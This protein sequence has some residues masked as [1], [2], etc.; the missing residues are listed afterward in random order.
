M[1]VGRPQGHKP[2]N[3]DKIG[4]RKPPRTSVKLLQDF[5]ALMD[6]DERSYEL[7]ALRAGVS[8]VTLSYWRHGKRTPSAQTLENVLQVLGY[9]LKIVPSI[10]HPIPA[11]P[12]D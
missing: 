6:R 4:V 10:S 2:K 11:P 3:I 12:E 9:S 1:P 8:K 7:I 5:F